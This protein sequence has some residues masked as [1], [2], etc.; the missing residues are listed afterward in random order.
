MTDFSDRML[1][2]LDTFDADEAVARTHEV[3]FDEITAIDSAVRPRLTG[4]FNHSFVPDMV[5]EWTDDGKAQSR[6]LFVRHSL[7]SSEASGDWEA[8]R[9]VSGWPIFLSVAPEEPDVGRASRRIR[10]RVRKKSRALMTTVPALQGLT[11]S[12]TV[13]DPIL[14][15]VR[16]NVVRGARGFVDE[17]VV[18][19]LTAPA[20][21]RVDADSLE[22]FRGAV[23]QAFDP[24]AQH[25]IGRVAS[26]VSAAVNPEATNESDWS[27]T[28]SE[29]EIRSL[30][31]YLLGLEEAA[32]NTDFWARLGAMITLGQLEAMAGSLDGLD[33]TPL[34]S[35]ANRIWV[36]KHAQLAI[37]SE[38]VDDETFDASPGW[39]ILSGALTAEVGKWR[40]GVY[41]NGQRL[42]GRDR[43]APA[44]WEDIR[45]LFESG[46]LTGVE[47]HGVSRRMTVGSDGSI[48]VTGDVERILANI[49]DSFHVPGLSLQMT[50]GDGQLHEF[51]VDFT[52]MLVHS[53][54]PAPLPLLIE[55]AVSV[56][57][58]RYPADVD[59]VS[60]L[61]GRTNED[62]NDDPLEADNN[63][64]EG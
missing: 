5:L 4:Y 52:S 38:S 61:L 1:A 48:D 9:E 32:A 28:L 19:R 17:D 64:G 46:N 26:I 34:A 63:R 58:Y 18:Q 40:A 7:L 33:L 37:R 62:A 6:D 12:A 13:A 2:A 43:S 60:L 20:N 49:E 59:D 29:P 23:R 10:R 50:A 45:G 14:S 47:L 30:L 3:V 53:K 21:R 35:A 54:G 25:R 39:R 15:V 42:K 22:E 8:L 27:G 56:L 11:T 44:R 31:P 36:A 57:G 51:D 41:L 24:G 16:A 55:A